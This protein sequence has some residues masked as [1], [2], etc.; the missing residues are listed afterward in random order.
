MPFPTKPQLVRLAVGIALFAAL[1]TLQ[2]EVQGLWP[3][4]LLAG[5]AFG[6]LTWSIVAATRK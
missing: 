4:V 6:I 1:M 2:S 5:G 3:R